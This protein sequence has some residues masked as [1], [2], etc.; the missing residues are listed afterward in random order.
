MAI[1]DPQS[2]LEI[3]ERGQPLV[4]VFQ[5]LFFLLGRDGGLLAMGDVANGADDELPVFQ[6]EV[7]SEE[8][9]VHGGAVLPQSFRFERIEIAQPHAVGDQRTAFRLNQFEQAFT[10]EFPA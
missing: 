4:P 2:G 10:Q 6:E 5:S 7:F 1:R 9:D 3:G 8:F